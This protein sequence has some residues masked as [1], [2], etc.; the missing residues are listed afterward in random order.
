MGEDPIYRSIS[1]RNLVKQR[2][3]QFI[4]VTKF[5]IIIAYWLLMDSMKIYFHACCSNEGALF[6]DGLIEFSKQMP[7]FV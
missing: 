4:G 3:P 5:E 7:E 2:I 6:C 1:K